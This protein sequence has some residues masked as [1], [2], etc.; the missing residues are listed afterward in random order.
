MRFIG[1][2]NAMEKSGQT[3]DAANVI[4]GDFSFKSGVAA[5]NELLSKADNRPT[6]IFAS[7][8][9]MAAGVVSGALRAGLSVPEDLSVC[10]FDDTPV[11]KILFPQLTTI[12]QP[13]H[14]MGYEA[15]SL[16]VSPKFKNAAPSVKDL[17]FELVIRGSA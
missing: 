10:G 2:C 6:A 9:D 11:A 17:D 16:L 12:R 5:A 3:I 8:D 14:A 15:V 7:N 13:I 1:F 4:R